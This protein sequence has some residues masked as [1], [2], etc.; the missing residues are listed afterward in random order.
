[1]VAEATD[2]G[3]GK[4]DVLATPAGFAE[5]VLGIGLYD[6]QRALLNELER[7]GMISARCC[8]EAGKTTHLA[9]PAILWAMALFPGAQVVVTS[10]AWRQVKYQLF[11]A[12]GR[13]R[14]KL[15]GW[16][17]H[18][19]T[20]KS[21]RGS[22]CVGFSTDDAGLFEG[23][24]VGSGGHR[25]T[26]LLI[27]VDEAKSVDETIFQAI[28]RCRPTWLFLM[29]SP[30]ARTG[31]FY[32]SH[33]TQRSHYRAYK[34]GAELCPHIDANT[35]KGIVDRYGADHWFVK[36]S[37][38]AEFSDDGVTGE[39]IPLTALERCLESPVAAMK[40]Q[41]HA[42][43]DFAAGRDENVL[44]LREG[45]RVRI[46][47]AWRES[48][49]MAACGEFITMFRQLGLEPHEVTGDGD[50]LGAG[51]LDRMAELGWAIG[52]FHGGQ[53]ATDK[54]V[55]MNASAEC[56]G[57]GA[58]QIQ[59]RLVHLPKDD[60]KL[61]EQLTSR[62]WK[63][64]SD[65]RAQLESKEDMRARGLNSP[66]RAD[67]VLGALLDHLGSAPD[68]RALDVLEQWQDREELAGL[69]GFNAGG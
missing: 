58:E 23:F 22:V 21:P 2:Q 43:C 5:G 28:D 40:G 59:R 47:R 39:V 56:W 30:G 45:N 52:R 64:Y 10:G 11:P 48:N 7:P 50:G 44:A 12:I 15:P 4:L 53:A 17:I 51:F 1:M 27:I 16:E 42:F 9:A 68:R 3:P 20:I 35:I 55:Y 41:R 33:T 67:A 32:A 66:D 49:T 54:V 8:N 65:G 62:R 13:F 18:D 14:Q 37:I 38:H 6:W 29:S 60:A 25:E 46:V 26:P 57:K 24:H 31:R 19:T 69:A 34:I 36:S 61:I 63:R